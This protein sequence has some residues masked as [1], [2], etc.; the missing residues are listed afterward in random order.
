MGTERTSFFIF[1]FAGEGGEFASC[2]ADPVANVAAD[3]PRVPPGWRQIHLLLPQKALPVF[4]KKMTG[5]TTIKVLFI[6]PVPP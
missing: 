3:L 1:S 2:P 6:I 5:R 4:A